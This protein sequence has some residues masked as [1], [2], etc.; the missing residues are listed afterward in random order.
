MYVQQSLLQNVPAYDILFIMT[1][2][3]LMNL[4]AFTC[5]V[6]GNHHEVKSSFIDVTMR[7]LF[8]RPVDW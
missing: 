2:T 5:I 1:T 6:N 8:H 4:T 7:T 3:I